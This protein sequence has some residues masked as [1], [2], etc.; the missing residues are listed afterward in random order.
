VAPDKITLFREPLERDFPDGREL[1]EEIR[2]TVLH[3]IAHF[4]GMSE[5]SVTE[6]GID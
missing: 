3:E 5:E 4:F 2:K 6:L 1:A